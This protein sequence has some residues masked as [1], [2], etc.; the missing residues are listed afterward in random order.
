MAVNRPEV[1]LPRDFDNASFPAL[2]GDFLANGVRDVDLSCNH[3][4]NGIEGG[5]CNIKS[6]FAAEAHSELGK[7][8]TE[9]TLTTWLLLKRLKAAGCEAD[10]E[11]HYPGT[12]KECALVLRGSDKRGF[13]IEVKYAWKGWYGCNGKAG[14]S[15]NFKGYLL[16]DYSH[17]GTAHD[18]RKLMKLSRLHARGLGVLLV[19][20]DS[21]KRPMDAEIVR[22]VEQENLT[23]EGWSL[24]A[25]K[26][27][28]D[29][30]N[31]SFRINCWFWCHA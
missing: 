18:F 15:P 2:L 3:L 16:G 30:R 25:H 27:W 11:V 29:R 20:L 14:R 5:L 4:I 24:A 9:E 10:A 19:G 23:A 28:P 12:R 6:R 7:R 21:L 22:L 31:D 13:W 26:S 8:L 1:F 17:P